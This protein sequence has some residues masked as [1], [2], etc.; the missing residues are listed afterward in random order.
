MAAHGAA[1]H[2]LLTSSYEMGWNSEVSSSSD[3]TL[4]SKGTTM[5]IEEEVQSGSSPDLT[6]LLQA[7]AEA[8]RDVKHSVHLH[9]V[10]GCHW[11]FPPAEA[12]YRD[13]WI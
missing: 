2:F 13:C 5:D 4:M 8:E 10:I 11:R 6:E 1:A 9:L 12:V 3:D 7:I